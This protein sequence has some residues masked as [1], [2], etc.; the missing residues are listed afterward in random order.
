MYYYLVG[1]SW[2]VVL[3]VFA[4]GFLVV[5]ALFAL[6]YLEVGGVSHVRPGSFTDAFFFSV[7][8]FATIGYGYMAP[9]TVGAHVLVTCETMVGL[10]GLAMATGLVFAKFSRPKARVV[11]SKVAVIAQRDG[12]PTLMFRV[13]NER[14]NH[15]VE[16]TLKVALTRATVTLEGERYRKMEDLKLIR[17]ESPAFI[18]TWTALHPITPDSPLYGA[19]PESLARDQVEILIILTGIDGTLG[20]TIHARFSYLPEEIRFNERFA[21]VIHT[22][23]NGR[24]EIVYAHF[25]ETVPVPD[26]D[27]ASGE[28]L[29][30]TGS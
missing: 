5:N 27:P 3:P 20:E 10:L 24:R 4:A 11:F 2:A 13:A 7:Q 8:S 19:T 25:H 12:V 15:V 30:Q 1:A 9:Q 16:A 26:A 21:D 28:K 17:S 14:A 22:R 18:I 29:P 23:P 6:L